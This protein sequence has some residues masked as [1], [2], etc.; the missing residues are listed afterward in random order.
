MV[1][2]RDESAI[3]P[4]RD[5]IGEVTFLPF[6]YGRATPASAGTRQANA[7][8]S[9]LQRAHE[10][11]N[12]PDNAMDPNIDPSKN[13]RSHSKGSSRREFL[14]R[15]IRGGALLAATKVLGNELGSRENQA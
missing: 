12:A 2:I 9:R 5:L 14:G 6:P 15:T 11:L 4:E 3:C 8:P 10:S 13:D 7:L 1:G